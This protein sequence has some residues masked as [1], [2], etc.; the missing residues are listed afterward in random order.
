M[1]VGIIAEDDS[2]VAVLHHITM[3][4]LRPHTVGLKKF[5]GNGCGKLRRKCAAWALNLA[6]RDCHWI[7]VVHDLD[8][9]NERELRSELQHAIAPAVFRARV[10]LIPKKEIEAWLL[11]DP[12][13]IATAFREHTLPRLPGN[14]ESLPDP[15]KHLG[16][17]IWGTY[18]KKYLN[19]IHNAQIAKHIQ[20]AR[21]RGC[22]SFAPHFEFTAAVRATIR[23]DAPGRARGIRR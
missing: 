6:E 20:A 19:T 3:N 17:L 15:K 8:E 4:L 21:L 5:V 2:D 18:K 13:A 22:P 23:E 11:Y 10:V 7:A 9:N 12:R 16:N 1:N 14:P